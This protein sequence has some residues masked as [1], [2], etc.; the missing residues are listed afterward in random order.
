MAESR[1]QWQLAS[2][3]TSLADISVDKNG[4]NI[5]FEYPSRQL[6]IV[7]IMVLFF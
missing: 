5:F 6:G 2:S 7:W 4:N 1:K 3:D